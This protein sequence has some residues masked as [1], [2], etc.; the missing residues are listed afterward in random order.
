MP[1]LFISAAS[2]LLGDH[3]EDS[4][5]TDVR[6]LLEALDYVTVTE[7]PAQESYIRFRNAPPRLAAQGSVAVCARVSISCTRRSRPGRLWS[8]IR[9]GNC[10]PLACRQSPGR[11]F[12]RRAFAAGSISGMHRRGY[13][14]SFPIADRKRRAAVVRSRRSGCRAWSAGTRLSRRVLGAP[15]APGC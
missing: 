4:N 14:I 3:S 6:L 11:R 8:R 2:K 15:P 9:S 13:R 1:N 10:G 7:F 12:R 5:A